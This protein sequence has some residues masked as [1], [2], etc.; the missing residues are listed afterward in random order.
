MPAPTSGTEADGIVGETDTFRFSIEGPPSFAPQSPGDVDWANL[1]IDVRANGVPVI[2]T[3]VPFT[4]GYTGVSG[5][6][7]PGYPGGAATPLPEFEATYTYTTPGTVDWTIDGNFFTVLGGGPGG[8][9]ATQTA[10]DNNVILSQTITGPNATIATSTGQN[11]G[12]QAVRNPLATA[13]SGYAAPTTITFTG[14]TWNANI[15]AGDIQ[16]QFCDVTGTTC[17]NLA[18]VGGTPPN[19]VPNVVVNTLGSDAGGNI[20]GQIDLTRNNFLPFLTTGNRAIKLTGTNAGAGNVALVPVLVLGTPTITLNPAAGGAGTIVLVSG[21]NMNPGAGCHDQRLHPDRLR[22]P[23][24]P[25]GGIARRHGQRRQRFA[26]RAP[27]SAEC[28]H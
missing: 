13:I 6:R 14:D 19:N 20:T 23:Y 25:P 7:E 11:A 8:V 5:V 17:D 16:A 28:G 2:A 15:A 18:L 1:T 12:V 21:S 22:R 24:L 10:V 26:P 27:I 3:P 9:E 4:G